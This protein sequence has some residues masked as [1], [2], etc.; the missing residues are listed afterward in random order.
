MVFSSHIFLFYFLPLVLLLNYTLPFRWLSLGLTSLSYVFYG[1]ANPKWVLL[2]LLSSYIDYFCGLV[3]VRGIP[4]EGNDLPF[5]PVGQP[6]ST[7][8]KVALIL[9]LTSNLSILG[10][11][12]YCDFFLSNVN[13]VAASFGFGDGTLRLLHIA[14]PVGVSFYTFQ[15]MSYAIDVYRGEARPLKNPI[16]FQLFVGL[17]PHMVAGPII[18]Y[19]TVAEQIRH[20]VFRYDK[21]AR[22]VAFVSLGLSKKILLANP[23]AYIADTVFGAASLHWYDAWYGLIAYAFQ[24]Y[25]DFAGYSDMAVG[26]GLM[27]GFLFMKNFNSPYSSESITELWRRWHISL[28]T[29]LRDYLYIPL[30]GNRYG[31]FR[32]Y[33]NLMTVML[34]GGLWHGASWNFMIWGGI[35]G[36]MLAAE[37][38]A[39]RQGLFFF[40][41]HAGR[42]ALTFATTCLGWVFFRS[43]TLPQSVSYFRSLFGLES[44]PAAAE[45]VAGAIYTP[46]YALCFGA[47]ALMT[48]AAPQAWD[49][50]QKL[51]PVRA[52]A[53]LALFLLSVSF[54]WTQ[55]S[56]PFLYYQF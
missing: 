19:Q 56:N 49:F 50:S 52:T 10:F 34:L 13:T 20:R 38:M 4:R 41:P 3:L 12:K 43:D 6:R 45:A 23:M 25:F 46:Y 24:I 28:S 36:G 11:F 35:H 5:L 51:T 47:C 54:M 15:S 42:V 53:C 7:R 55:N 8:Q 30:G 37:R 26:L 18:R 44:V 16:D 21:F 40:L 1:W 9:S 31:E 2:L 14:L 32:T 39:G 29:W 27:L 48:W 17:F 33:A 22:G